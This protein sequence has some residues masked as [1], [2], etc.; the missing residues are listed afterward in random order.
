MQYDDNSSSNEEL[1]QDPNE[2]GHSHHHCG[3]GHEQK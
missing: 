1:N 3:H 2:R